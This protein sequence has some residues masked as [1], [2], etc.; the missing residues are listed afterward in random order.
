MYFKHFQWTVEKLYE[1]RV[2]I[3][4]KPQYQRGD[5]WDDKHRA[6]LIDSILSN[7]DIPKIYLSHSNTGLYD[8]EVADGQQRLKAL[9]RFLDN[10]LVLIGM[11]AEQVHL[12]GKK[13][14]DLK[15]DEKRRVM[16]FQIGTA[17]FYNA[18][19]EQIR[20][21]FRRLQLGIKLNPAELRNS[22]SSALGNVIRAMALTHD[23]FRKSPFP[24][25]RYKVDDLVA[26]AFAIVIYNRDR[27]VKAPDLTKMYSE[28]AK[29]VP[30]TCAQKVNEILN[31]MN[32]MQKHA[33]KCI[34]T[35]WGFVD[36]VSVLEK[37]EL[38]NLDAQAIVDAYVAWE[39]D[40]AENLGRLSELAAAKSGSRDHLLFEYITAFQ[41]EGATKRNLETRFRVL[42]SVVP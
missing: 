9:W 38:Q 3:D 28:Y 31:F 18:N 25:S 39:R 10:E 21:L 8:Y 20:E 29:N 19:D 35:K 13:Y 42:N 30:P 14:Q 15:E 22:M 11:S 2:A 40:R 24:I 33:Q 5:A 4:P 37:R 27:D 32:E 16:Q 26:H 17:V 6:L 12:N 7:F 41:K 23:F 1:L 36:L 34:K